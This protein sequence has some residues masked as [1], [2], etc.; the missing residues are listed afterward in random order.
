MFFNAQTAKNL[1]FVTFILLSIC[2]PCHA[3]IVIEGGWFYEPFANFP[4]QV[5]NIGPQTLA[6]K[7]L[8]VSP[9]EKLIFKI[10]FLDV[11]RRRLLR[12][13]EPYRWNMVYDPKGPYQI[14]FTVSGNAI[15]PNSGTTTYNAPPGSEANNVYL[16]IDDT[17]DETTDITVTAT[18]HDLEVT[19]PP[20]EGNSRDADKNFT[21]MLTKRGPYTP[22]SE[23]IVKAEINGRNIGLGEEEVV[24]Y[25]SPMIFYHQADPGTGADDDPPPNAVRNAAH[26]FFEG[27]VVTEIIGEPKPLFSL[28]DVRMEWRQATPERQNLTLSEIANL[29]FSSQN[30]SWTLMTVSVPTIGDVPDV[31]DDNF[32]GDFNTQFLSIFTDEALA[33]GVSA[34]KSQYYVAKNIL[35]PGYTIK[36]THKTGVPNT[37]T[38]VRS[39][40]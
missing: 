26:P 7:K 5:N 25:I 32:G 34:E 14:S 31:W 23:H 27:Q 38:F 24:T 40:K 10:K 13:P 19:L 20:D 2:V 6:T 28:D 29:L 37:L 8:Q 39:A 16:K 17:W 9:G 11:D 18:F 30:T 36:A 35:G 1:S 3:Q 12:E 15:F 33:K 21:W 4:I 22:K